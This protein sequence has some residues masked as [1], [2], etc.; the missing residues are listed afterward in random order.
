MW[1]L[2]SRPN[3]HEHKDLT[4]WFQGPVQRGYQKREAAL[5]NLKPA[6]ERATVDSEKLGYGPRTISA[7]FPSSQA[8]G[9]GGQSFSNFLASTARGCLH[10]NCDF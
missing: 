9:V 10:M 5:R 8:F 3:D 4:C 1:L 7:V 6:A 2:L